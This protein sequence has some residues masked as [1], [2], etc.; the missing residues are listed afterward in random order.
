MLKDKIVMCMCE[1][2]EFYLKLYDPYI[3]KGYYCYIYL[4][5]FIVS[6][7][8]VGGKPILKN[9][10]YYYKRYIIIFRA[11]DQRSGKFVLCA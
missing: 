7:I 10:L 3:N 9:I 1:Y 2:H 4:I 11:K 6:R 8:K 5:F